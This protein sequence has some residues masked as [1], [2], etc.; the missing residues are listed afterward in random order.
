MNLN[1][2]PR[3]RWLYRGIVI[4]AAALVLSGTAQISPPMPAVDLSI[5]PVAVNAQAV[6]I[7]LAL[8]VEWPTVGS[9]YRDTSY[10]YNHSKE[11]VGYWDHK[12]C[13]EYRD[14]TPGAPISGEYFY[15]TGPVD[16]TGYCNTAGAGSGWSGNA[17]NYVA[18]SSI[19]LLRLALTG[20]NRV[21]DGGYTVSTGSGTATIDYT[22][23]ERAYLRNDWNLNNAQFRSR[24]IPATYRGKVTP[25]FAGTGDV[26]GG[27]CLDRVWFGSGISSTSCTNPSD[28]GNLNARV[29]DPSATSTVVVTAGGP[30]PT[31]PP[32]GTVVFVTTTWSISS[33]TTSVAPS[34]GPIQ[35]Y[36]Y[37]LL[38]SG[39]STV[40]PPDYSTATTY[41]YTAYLPTGNTTTV[42]P[43]SPEPTVILGTSTVPLS[44]QRTFSTIAPSAPYRT[45]TYSSSS[46]NV[47]RSTNSTSAANFGGELDSSGNLQSVSSSDCNSGPFAAFD[48]RGKIS[49]SRTVYEQLQVVTIYAVHSQQKVYKSYTTETAYY[50]FNLDK[51]QYTVTGSKPGIMYA[52]VRVCDGA[53]ATQ[54][55]DVCRRYPDGNYKPVGQIQLNAESARVAAFGYVA[56]DGNGRNGGV[57]RAPMHFTGPEYRDSAGIMQTNTQPEWNVNN[58]VFL[59]DPMGVSPTFAIS[60]VINYLNKFGTTGVLGKY[61]ENDPVGELYYE[62]LRYFQGLGPTPSSLANMTTTFYDGFPIYGTAAASPKTL[63]GWVDPVQ[64]S[65]QRRNFILTIG[66][67]NTHQDRNLPGHGTGASSALVTAG[68]PARAVEPL[69]GDATKNFN[70]VDWTALIT[71]FETGVSRSYTDALG[72]AQNTLG[73]PNPRSA[74]SNLEGKNGGCCEGA[75]YWAGAA[76]WANT[77]PIRL[78][79]KAGKSMRDVRVKTFT[80]DVDEGGNGDIE[81]TNPRGIKPRNSTFYLAGKYGWFNDA[82]LDGNPF[83]TSGGGTPTNA[84]WEDESA[85]NTPGGYVIA[86]QAQKLLDG[87]KKFFRAATSEKGAVSVSSL[88]SQRFTTQEPNGDLFSPRFDSRDWSGTVQRSGLKFN[89]ATGK[90]E[91]LAGVKWDAGKIL[92]DSSVLGT[93]TAA[94]GPQ[95]KPADR[96]I[97][98]LSRGVSVTTGQAFTVANKGSLDAAV[99]AALNKN[100]TTNA[101]DSNADA[102]INWIRGVR[103]NE[104]NSTGG[105]L[106]RRL[107]I[108]GD[109]IN[110]GP[111]FKQGADPDISGSGY[112]AFAS[113][114]TSRAAMIY[115]G[116]NDGMLHG[117][118]ATDGKEMF[119]YIP[120]AVAENLNK[121]TDPNYSH[122]PYV[123]G[124]PTVSEAQIGSSWKTVLASGMGGGAQ[125]IFVLDVTTP[126]T[127]NE[128]NVMFE[129]TDRD[130]PDM[131]N[132]L[133]Q[134]KIVKMRMAG[135]GTPTYKWFVV[136][137]SGYNN[138]VNDGY[139]SLTGKQAL[140]FLSLDKAPNA[141]WANG[142]NYFKVVLAAPTELTTPTGLS[143]PGISSGALGEGVLFYS[144]DLQ[145]NM[146]RF[147]FDNG[148]D[149]TNAASAVKVSGGSPVPMFVAKD[150]LGKRQP[151]T[152]SPQ[153]FAGYIKGKMV[154]FG[155]GKFI[156]P[157]DADNVDVQSVYGVWDRLATADADYQIGRSKLF[158]RT[159][160]VGTATTT[161]SGSDTFAFG[162]GSSSTYRG[163]FVDLPASRERVAVEGAKF[164]DVALINTTIPDG[165]CS[166][167]GSGRQLCVT[168]LYGLQACDFETSTAGLLSRP[169]VVLIEDTSSYDSYKPRN[170]TGRRLTSIK[171]AALSTGTKITDAGNVS[172]STTAINGPAIPSGRMSWREIRNFRE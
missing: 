8:S 104:Q 103:D 4:T 90:I 88:S 31:A 83:K 62:T 43:T 2:L 143:N 132:I 50:V 123:D 85:P 49:G 113:S 168:S 163:W 54:R 112:S 56:E 45:F 84:E 25:V 41:L 63:A 147:S 51:D 115:V 71:G 165:G 107:N 159:M 150:G 93:A 28:H 135:S 140:F 61:K 142:T 89:T 114:V 91:A 64:N 57:L 48:Y 109:V 65:C 146:W 47:C 74:N 60:G 97:F 19:D 52:R 158:Q 154:V 44:G 136:V 46:I 94:A 141:A 130:D 32:G 82:N 120:R 131:G 126:T 11:Y 137:G 153:I 106:R 34:S 129:F 149:S 161:L 69:L 133:S 162:D 55:P 24:V 171:S 111:I 92:T 96:K 67:V 79:T 160:T 14:T 77:Q 151:V 72:R 58:G 59:T 86:S 7:A 134:P 27:S 144:G 87:I 36:N 139:Y 26:W 169:N 66:D 76:Y 172:S 98:T 145:G 9:A 156:E 39:T 152:T 16:A 22:V 33:N 167:D 10:T 99:L 118:Q 30:A 13:Y 6:N 35:T 119:A 102:R 81:D 5:G 15:R 20:G 148:L 23:L 108:M 17:L 18:T 125:G 40:V 78:D 117:F 68:Q 170:A 128:S 101:T 105:F 70:A 138:Y 166:G 164:G 38:G 21:V 116:A 12:A 95:V 124:V 122:R 80:I 100:A 73:N 1:F 3:P 53:S 29:A 42:A 37:T 155:T 157:S 110:S 127:F 121:L 75:Y